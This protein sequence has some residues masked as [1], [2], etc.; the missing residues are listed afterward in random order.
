M[1]IKLL[2]AGIILNT[3]NYDRCVSF[4]GKVLGLRFLF[5]KD[6]AE[7]RL[8]C[9]DFGGAYLMVESGGHANPAGKSLKENC[10]KLRLNVENLEA[11]RQHFNAHGIE[12]RAALLFA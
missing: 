10:S 1:T 8:T 11:A 12:A 3:E 2:R 7:H 9:F 6:E 4:Y 5:S